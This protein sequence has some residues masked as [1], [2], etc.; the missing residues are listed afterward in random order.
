[1][2]TWQKSGGLGWQPEVGKFGF[3]IQMF[4]PPSPLLEET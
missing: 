3:G 1:M 2:S 4:A